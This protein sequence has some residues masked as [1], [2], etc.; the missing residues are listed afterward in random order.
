MHLIP[1]RGYNS[2][3]IFQVENFQI[4]KKQKLIEIYVGRASATEK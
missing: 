1:V 2:Q 4:H 3:V